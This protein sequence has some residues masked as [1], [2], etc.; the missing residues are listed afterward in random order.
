MELFLLLINF[1]C[2]YNFGIFQTLL[3]LNFAYNINYTIKIFN[4]SVKN[5]KEQSDIND[6]FKQY[7]IKY[8]NTKEKIMSFFII[9][10]IYDIMEY[11][12]NIYLRYKRKLIFY[13]VGQI[14][15][16]IFGFNINYFGE[17]K[18][19]INFKVPLNNNALGNLQFDEFDNL[20]RE[21][22]IKKNKNHINNSNESNY[23]PVF[24]SNEDMKSFLDNLN[25]NK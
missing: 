12:N 10:Q 6:I 19:K 22:N 18:D 3:L 25:K 20:F 5:Y 14:T 16:F 1:T 21:Q 15:N 4:T 24:N 23:K 11:S 2:I 8:E 7:I 9:K 13:I 17:I